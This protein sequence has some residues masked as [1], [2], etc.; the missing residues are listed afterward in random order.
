MGNTKDYRVNLQATL[1]LLFEKQLFYL[2]LAEKA[3]TVEN[4][5]SNISIQE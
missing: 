1:S 4:A 3:S 2:W 5:S